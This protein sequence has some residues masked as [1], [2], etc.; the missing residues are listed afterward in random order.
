M[1]NGGR[2]V[3]GGKLEREERILRD[4][5]E[6]GRLRDGEVLSSTRALAAQMGIS[7]WPVNKA[8]EQLTEDGLRP[9]ATDF[10]IGGHAG[11][12]KSED[13]GSSQDPELVQHLHAHMMD[14][15][16]H[17]VEPGGP[18]RSDLLRV[19]TWQPNASNNYGNA[20]TRSKR[21]RPERGLG[22]DEWE[23]GRQ[24]RGHLPVL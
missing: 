19:R 1:T 10:L 15:A 6:S 8:M 2:A 12:G 11:S 18:G 5:I 4:Y 17:V 9:D 3:G 13:P 23:E 21:P 22:R 7:V 14:R 16:V 24:G 20:R